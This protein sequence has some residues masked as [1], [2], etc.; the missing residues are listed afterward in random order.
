M[1]SQLDEELFLKALVLHLP[2]PFNRKIGEIFLKLEFAVY[3]YFCIL[4][5][6]PL[7]C[8]TEGSEAQAELKLFNK[9]QLFIELVI[10][11]IRFWQ[12]GFGQGFH[13]GNDFL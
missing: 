9:A 12:I 7:A 6:C 4:T 2:Q 1:E 11:S 10:K 13:C 5:L 8:L 3:L